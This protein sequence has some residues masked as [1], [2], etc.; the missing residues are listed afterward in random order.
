MWS[1]WW[2]SSPRSGTIFRAGTYVYATTGKAPSHMD[3]AL[4]QGTF[5]KK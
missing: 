5:R 1:R 2:W 4:L 3:P